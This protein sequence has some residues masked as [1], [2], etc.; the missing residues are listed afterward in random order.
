LKSPERNQAQGRSQYSDAG[1]WANSDPAAVD[2]R[3][4][5]G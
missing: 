2:K 3:V 4:V 5:R 1:T